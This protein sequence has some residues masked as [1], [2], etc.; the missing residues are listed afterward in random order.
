MTLMYAQVFIFENSRVV[1]LMLYLMK[2]INSAS[3]CTECL[4]W[5]YSG[6]RRSHRCK[7]AKIHIQD[8]LAQILHHGRK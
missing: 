3:V 8:V 5:Y 1:D 6:S 2:L 7:M 4:Y